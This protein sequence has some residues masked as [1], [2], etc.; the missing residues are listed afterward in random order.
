MVGLLE[1]YRRV[2]LEGVPPDLSQLSLSLACIV[3]V[4][5]IAWPLFRILSQYFSDVL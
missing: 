2:L 5:L 1:G 3:L 4:G